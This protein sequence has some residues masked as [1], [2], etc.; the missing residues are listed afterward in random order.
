MNS[1]IIA[2]L[3]LLIVSIFYQFLLAKCVS[4][5]GYSSNGITQT[6]KEQSIIEKDST[7]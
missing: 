3:H 5:N 1:K 4:G 2:Q 7:I 6:I